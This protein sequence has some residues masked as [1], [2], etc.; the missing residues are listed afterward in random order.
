VS[1]SK[2]VPTVVGQTYTLSFFTS[3][4][5][6]PVLNVG[7]DKGN[8]ADAL[9]LIDGSL[10]GSFQTQGLPPPVVQG[11]Q[12]WTQETFK[13]IAKN[14]KTNIEFQDDLMGSGDENFPDSSNVVIAD[15]TIVP[16]T[17]EILGIAGAAAFV[18]L[19]VLGKHRANRF[20]G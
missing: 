6:T 16:E 14:A 2:L 1:I 15:V 10:V 9:L 19:A 4:E 7:N 12:T 13:F 18:G 17:S 5:V 3:T 11:Q 20:V 8:P